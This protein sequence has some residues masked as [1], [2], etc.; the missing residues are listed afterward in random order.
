MY[1]HHLAP[2]L[3]LGF[4]VDLVTGA[5]Q[6]TEGGASLFIPGGHGPGAGIVPPP[7]FYFANDFF[8]YSG[9]LTGGRRIQIGGAVLADVQT[10]VRADFLTATWVTPLEILGGRTAI[11]ISLPFGVPRV[12]AG[13]L[14]EAPRVGRTFAFSQRDDSFVLGDPVAAALI[15]WDAGKFHWQAGTTVSIPAGGYEE[16]EL[17]NLAFNRWIGDVYA[18]LTWLDPELGL[19]LSGAVGFE[20]NGE[21]PDTDYRSGNA[22]HIDVSISKNLTKEFSVGLLA[23]Y[24]DQVSSD[25]GAGN[26]IGP[27]K[28]RVT[29][30]GATAGY[31]F[32]VA[33]T[34][35]SARIKV[36]REVDVENRPQGTIGL[37]TVGFP[38][39]APTA[40][41]PMRPVTAKY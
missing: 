5:A 7:G 16:G 21:N 36:L 26:R 1:R 12:S 27:F 2:I 38:L 39:G 35:V 10:E 25:T 40:P 29:A 19:D 41:A 33:G 37:F 34:P 31:D 28:G 32:T 17:S 18:A 6:A 23:G 9:E 13:V 15:G 20:F 3:A 14:I 24:Y 8:A 22:F 4:L 11:G 30:V